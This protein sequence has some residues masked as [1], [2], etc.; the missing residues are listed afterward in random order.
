MT[1][2]VSL[3]PLPILLSLTVGAMLFWTAA[4][5]AAARPNL[6]AASI[7]TAIVAEPSRAAGRIR[8]TLYQA[9]RRAGLDKPLTSALIGIFAARVDFR[10][11]VHRGDRFA[12]VYGHR[13]HHAGP[14]ILAAELDLENTT[15]RVFRHA[16]RDGRYR[17]YTQAGRTLTPTLLRTPVDYT[18]VSSPFS[19]RRLNPVLHI[20]RPHYGVDLAAPTGTPIH[21]AGN[22]RVVFR[23]RDGAYGNLVIIRNRRGRYSTR[24]AHMVRFAK[25][26]HVGSRVHQGE[27]IGYVG[28][29]GMTTG[30][31]LHFEI[32]VHGA[33]KN[34][35]TVKLPSTLP[36]DELT[37][38]HAN[39]TPL[40]AELDGSVRLPPGAIARNAVTD[41]PAP[42]YPSAHFAL[43]PGPRCSTTPES[44]LVALALLQHERAA[45]PAAS[46]E[47]LTIG[48]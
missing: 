35:L 13:A 1:R 9:A 36:A 10:H 12:V 28:A 48:Q 34:P 37:A 7:I 47:R 25:N 5:Q 41:P 3:H 2:T 17:Y 30:P 8:H 20:Y 16:G 31:H 14:V 29:T 27:V 24:Y 32:R 44:A 18:H 33:P 4:G 42:A 38:F 43:P 21:A 23:G 6:T 19:L 46:P 15:L 22:G 39:I 26:I 45:L 40:V 11:D